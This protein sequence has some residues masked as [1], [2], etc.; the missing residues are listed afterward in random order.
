MTKRIKPNAEHRIV[1]GNIVPKEIDEKIARGR[2]Y[3]KEKE[4]LNEIEQD[5]EK[6]DPL[7]S[8]GHTDDPDSLLKDNNPKSTLA[9]VAA[10]EPSAMQ[11][12]S[13]MIL[14]LVLFIALIGIMLYTRPDM[15]WQIQKINELQD[16]VS[17]LKSENQTTQDTLLTLEQSNQQLKQ[18]LQQELQ[19]EMEAK[20]AKLP[21][22]TNQVD[23]GLAELRQ[24]TMAEIDELKQRLAEISNL[25]ADEINKTLADVKQRITQASNQVAPE[26]L[27]QFKALQQS[28]EQQ[29]SLVESQLSDLFAFKK[30]QQTLSKQP[31]QLTLDAPLNSLQIQQWIVEINTHWLLNGKLADTQ[32]QLYALEQ[33]ASLSDFTHTTQLARLIGQDLAYLKQL[34]ENYSEINLPDTQLLKQAI[35]NLQFEAKVVKESSGSEADSEEMSGFDQLMQKF[36]QLISLKQRPAEGEIV[37]VNQLLLSDVVKQRLALMADQIDWGLKTQS[38]KLIVSSADEIKRTVKEFFP[39]EFSKFNGLLEEF[40]NYRF[41]AKSPL[42]IMRLDETIQNES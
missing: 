16:Q 10:K 39:Q 23:Q 19:K 30:E 6:E 11:K 38:H 28:L 5:L 26:I 15:D 2:A 22:A 14:W 20:I 21:S 31:H 18:E 9:D 8:R 1:D 17:Q 24:N 3:S 36:S 41:F 32:Q 33:A 25:S 4:K 27:E 37:E 42:A 13:S 29:K 34:E 12:Y 7:D 35:G 40:V